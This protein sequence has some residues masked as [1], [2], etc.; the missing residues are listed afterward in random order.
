VLE[1][2][3]TPPTEVRRAKPVGAGSCV[4]CAGGITDTSVIVGIAAIGVIIATGDMA[5]TG[6][7]VA[8]TVIAVIG[9]IGGTIAAT[10]RVAIPAAV[11]RYR[12]L[13]A[14]QLLS[15]PP[16]PLKARWRVLHGESL[17]VIR[18]RMP[19]SEVWRELAKPSRRGDSD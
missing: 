12:F 13:I 8:I 4:I 11:R 18:A 1:R 2:R 19:F 3:L 10:A 14:E 6:D 15:A 7:T 5:A 17:A 9:I 16:C